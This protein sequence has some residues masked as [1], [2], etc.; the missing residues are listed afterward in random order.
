MTWEFVDFKKAYDRS[1]FDCG[2]PALNDY[3]KTKISQDVERKANVPLLA[4]NT[5]NIVVGFY[6][7]SSGSVEFKNFP[8]SLKNKISPY[9]VP[10]ALIGRLAVDNSMKGLGLGKELLVHAIT[11][12]EQNAKTIGIRAIVVD[13]KNTSAEN[14]YNKYGFD[15]LILA[16]TAYPRKMFLII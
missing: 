5:E 6:T 10:V 12:V 7:L 8:S 15:S 9:P 4:I 13:A 2:E 14:F 16:K 11:R 3:L 1:V